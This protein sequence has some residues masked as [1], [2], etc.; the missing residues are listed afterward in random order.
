VVV[1]TN[2]DVVAAAPEGSDLAFYL[3]ID[4]LELAED[5]AEETQDDG[6]E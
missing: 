1:W 6:S 2:G 4:V 3:P 5:T